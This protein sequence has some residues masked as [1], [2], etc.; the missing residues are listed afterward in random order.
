MQE[1]SLWQCSFVSIGGVKVLV[2]LAL[3]AL[4]LPVQNPQVGGIEGIVVRAGTNEPI[5]GVELRLSSVSSQ[6]GIADPLPT[7]GRDGKFSIS[8]L[9][10]G[11]YLAMAMKSGYA[12]QIYGSRQTGITGLAGIG[13][14][15]ED[16]AA[17]GALI[18]VVAGQVV[19]DLV[20]RMT[21]S[22]TV[23]GR[24]LGSNG[25]PL[26]SMQVELLPE[27]FDASGRR[28]L[29]PLT[30]VDTDDRGEYRLFS[31]EPGR[32]YISAR[33]TRIALARQEVNSELRTVDAA[34]SNGQRYAPAY[35]PSSPDLARAVLVDVKA[36]DALMSMDVTMRPPSR[37]PRRNIRG[38]VIDATTGQAPPLNSGPTFALIPRDAE[39]LNSL[40]AWDPHLM[41]DGSF[42]LRDV[43]EGSYW[44]VVRLTSVRTN[45]GTAG[46]TAVVP[47]NLGGGDIERFTVNLLPVAAVSG[48][49]TLDGGPWSAADNL[50]IRLNA[51]RIGAFTMN[52]SANP[53]RA[54]FQSDGTFV[55][56]NVNPADYDL[57]INGL[58]PDAYI[59]LARFGG[60]DALAQRIAISGPTSTLLEVDVSTKAGQLTGVVL[61]RDRKPT[62]GVEAILIPEGPARRPDRYKTA[63]TDANGRFL[64]RG[65]APGNYRLYAFESIERFRY[66]DAE[67]VRPFESFG[68]SVRIEEGARGTI[69]LDM[70]PAEK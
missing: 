16:L 50:Q 54:L 9:A 56:V 20:F 5:E 43:A 45:A 42:E 47:L 68:K 11:R 13:T 52:M 39:Y 37:Q 41:A 36:G 49:V 7:T 1:G 30:Q 38:R 55:M 67:F 34:D 12:A 44:F 23:S 24:V 70:I 60:V 17:A 8:G 58:P 6:P 57:V 4:L 32:Y 61:D 66:F 10:P 27:T 65:I 15:E 69:D 14:R 3:A 35:Y 62:P 21:P 63:R 48:K 46:R 40:P 28:N 33:W 31:V 59:K 25:E 22:A 53:S 51:N 26:V 18:N 29:I 19:R 64:L 2:T